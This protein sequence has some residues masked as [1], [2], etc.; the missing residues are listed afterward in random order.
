MTHKGKPCHG[1]ALSDC[2]QAE[3]ARPTPTVF[4]NL[5]A[6][7]SALCIATIGLCTL[8]MRWYFD[9]LVD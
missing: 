3:E 5:E 6:I 8:S 4:G 1:A 7:L 2:T 9:Y